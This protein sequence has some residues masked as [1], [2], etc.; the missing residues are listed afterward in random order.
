MATGQVGASRRQQ[1]DPRTRGA[2]VQNG[3]PGPARAR[4][5]LNGHRVAVLSV[6]AALLVAQW[7]EPSRLM[8]S[9]ALVPPGVLTPA[10]V[11]T[12]RTLRVVMDNAYAPFVFQSDEG[13]LQGILIDQWRAWEKKTGTRVEIRGMDWSE[14]LRRMRAGEF[15]VIDCIVET[16]RRRDDFDFTAPY[17]TIEASI[18]FRKDISGITD[19]ASLKGFP[20]GVK[21]GDQ[22]T[23]RI[24]ANGVTT[25]ILFR[26]NDEIIEAAKQH[27]INTFVVD[28][29]SAL[30]LLNKMGIDSEFRHSAPIFR[31]ELRRAV[32]K[33]DAAL[34]RRVS[35]GFS[36]IEPDELKRID[37]KWFGRTINRI[38]RY[39]TY[40]GYAAAAAILLVAAL[41]GW[42]RTLKRAILQ[43]TAALGES[44]QRFRQIAENI[45]E[46]FWVLDVSADRVTFVSPMYEELFGRSCASLYANAR[47]YL[48]AIH[49][50]DRARVEAAMVR[51]QAGTPTDE[52]YR[53]VRSDGSTRWVRD[54]AFPVPEPTGGVKRVVGVAE[55]I[56]DRTR[57][58]EELRQSE[59]LLQLVLDALPVG[60]AVVDVSGDIILSNPAS[61]RIWG[62]SISHGR[63]RYA[64]SKGWWHAT[65]KRIAVREWASVRAVANGETSVNEVLDIE[66]FGGARK[67]IQNSAVP[68]RD[69]NDRITGAVFVNEDISDRKKAE[70][71][72]SDSYNQMRTLTGRLMRAQ[73]DERR[74][75]AQMLHETTA[76]D[77]AALKMLLARLNRMSDRLSD[78][79]RNALT[80]S[81][82]LAE[83]SMTDIRTLSYLLHPPFLDE[84][85]LLSALRWYAAGFAERSGI[86]V[87][88]ELPESFDRLPLDT[89]T[90]LFRI[91]QESLINIHRHARSETACIRLRRDAETLVLE[92]E[93]RGHGIPKA[94]LERITAGKTLVGV[95]IA[96]MSERVEQLG[97]CFEITSHDHGTTV[98]A[99][100]PLKQ[101]AG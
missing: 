33:G 39:L 96:G 63:E 80:G 36:V 82:S 51:Q 15:D 58:E 101:E 27:K 41:V 93:D 4:S 85:G 84:M 71:E 72:L 9:P 69:A 70:R 29:P 22:H 76:Q 60:V 61:R 83:Q 86:K 55:D 49:G 20:V 95:G 74:R 94:S 28:D 13:K 30:Y 99:R 42:N 67:V 98:R 35:E 77:L 100:L 38:G 3:S 64:E 78:S 87:D 65:G 53:V 62:G 24:K 44:E 8:S 40:G 79:E 90:A 6:T 16:A 7:L 23:D 14:A 56:T 73:D 50:D 52:Q 57:A 89:E 21:T 66:D 97:G 34:L 68:I 81:M 75:I 45:R 17:T 25:L 10:A 48:D 19:L 12:P 32:R 91:V 59:R 47:S 11:E 18:Y 54:R 26:S 92:I 31:D 37:E 46:V 1:S 2:V 43:R 5:S 88:L